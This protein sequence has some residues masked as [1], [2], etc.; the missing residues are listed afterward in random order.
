MIKKILD[1]ETDEIYVLAVG[2]QNP[3]AKNVT[4]SAQ[5]WAEMIKG[6]TSKDVTL[7]HKV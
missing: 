7:T 2:I 5:T 6:S 3:T 1:L 4:P